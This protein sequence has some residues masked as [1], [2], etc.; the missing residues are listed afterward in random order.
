MLLSVMVAVRAASSLS[1]S[2]NISF[3]DGVMRPRF[4][5]CRF[6]GGTDC[7]RVSTPIISQGCGV[8]AVPGSLM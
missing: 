3:P 2:K 5:H 7:M 4:K 8:S 1:L 6:H